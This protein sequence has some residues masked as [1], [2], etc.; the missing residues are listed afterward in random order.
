VLG[1]YGIYKSLKAR[2]PAHWYTDADDEASDDD[3][4]EASPPPAPA[5]PDKD[6][7]EEF[8]K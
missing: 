7:D 8:T 2:V 4:D 5:K 3:T 6:V 1:Y